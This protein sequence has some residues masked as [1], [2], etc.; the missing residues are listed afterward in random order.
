MGTNYYY[1]D[2]YCD[3][4]GRYHRTHI[5]KSSVGWK[6]LFRVKDNID[7]NE[8]KEEF[9]HYASWKDEEG[10]FDEY[11]KKTSYDA[12]WTLVENKQ[13]GKAHRTPHGEINRAWIDENG[14]NV[15][16]YDFS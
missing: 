9:L 15:C 16:N 13:S 12:F 7:V 10:I 4:C 8:W 3:Q 6:F 14:Y 1:R 2:N 5:G 11:G